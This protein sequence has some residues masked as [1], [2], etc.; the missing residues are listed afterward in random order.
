MGV[1]PATRIVGGKAIECSMRRNPIVN[2]IKIE[3]FINKK[4]MIY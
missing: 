3:G 2:S 1:S 4:E